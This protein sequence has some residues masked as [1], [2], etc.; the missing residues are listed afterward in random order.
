MG[1]RDRPCTSC[2][3]QPSPICDQI[4]LRLCRGLL[5]ALFWP[6]RELSFPVLCWW[7]VGINFHFLLRIGC[8]NTYW[9]IKQHYSCNPFQCLTSADWQLT[10][11]KGGRMSQ[12]QTTGR[13][14]L[15][16]SSCLAFWAEKMPFHAPQKL[17]EPDNSPASSPSALFSI[18]GSAI[19]CVTAT[20][21]LAPTRLAGDTDNGAERT[22]GRGLGATAEEGRV[23]ANELFR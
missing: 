14:D 9:I 5:S 13:G 1:Q 10:T 18:C 8:R 3:K 6:C 23:H 15:S 21:V 16:S 20:I 22:Q 2:P 7:V 12:E 4:S 11:T 17:S 19:V